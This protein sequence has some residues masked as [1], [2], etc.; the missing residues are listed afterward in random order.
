M[1]KISGAVMASGLIL[2]IIV[3]NMGAFINQGKKLDN[4][5]DNVLRLHILANSD[6]TYDQN[7][8]LCVRDALIERSDEIFGDAQNF[9]QAENNVENQ[10]ALVEEIAVETLAQQNCSAEVNAELAQMYFEERVYGDITMPA[11]EYT[12]L[13]VEIGEA[14]GQNWWCVMYPPLCLPA[15][16]SEVVDEDEEVEEEFFDEEEKEIIHN[17]RKFKIR[18]AVWD[19]LKSLLDD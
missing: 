4:L 12:A 2:T 1:R 5:R 10:L 13:R 16:C 6:S 9:T 3:S 17:P 15:A 11:G 14:E 19:K 18:F 8:K 7:L